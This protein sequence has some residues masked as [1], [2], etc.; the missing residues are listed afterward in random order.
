MVY[1]D[2][3]IYARVWESGSTLYDIDEGGFITEE[4]D[5]CQISHDDQEIVWYE[6]EAIDPVS[7]MTNMFVE[8]KDLDEAKKVVDAAIKYTKDW[9]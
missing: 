3:E 8:L 2:H 6:V 4:I 1:K 7:G 9:I 5:G